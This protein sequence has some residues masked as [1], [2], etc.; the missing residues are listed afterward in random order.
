MNECK[1]EGNFRSHEKHICFYC[2]SKFSPG[3]SETCDICNWKKCLN[4]H[5][6]CDVS[7]ETKIALDKFYD[8]FCDS[9]NNY[10]VETKNVLYFM[11]KT[12][13][14]YCL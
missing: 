13:W 2:F 9:K 11:I 8:L 12:Y 7:K 6:G 14:G 1:R 5:C 3:I 10:S 4:G